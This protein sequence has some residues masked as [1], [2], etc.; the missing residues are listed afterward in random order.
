MTQQSAPQAVQIPVLPNN[1]FLNRTNGSLTSAVV[2]DEENNPLAAIAVWNA[3]AVATLF[4]DDPAIL[5]TWAADLA[6]AAADLRSRQGKLIV[7]AS[8]L[9]VPGR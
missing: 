4:V 6:R 7:P 2:A 9:L 1:P 5:D 3:G 8:T